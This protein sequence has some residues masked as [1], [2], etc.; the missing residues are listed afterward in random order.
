VRS[1]ECNCRT[2]PRKRPTAEPGL[3]P[4]AGGRV[5]LR[6]VEKGGEKSCSHRLGSYSSPTGINSQ[7]LARAVSACGR[8]RC[9][10]TS[11]RTT[12]VPN[13]LSGRSN[14]QSPGIHSPPGGS[15]LRGLD[16]GAPPGP[17]RPPCYQLYQR[18]TPGRRNSR[19]AEMVLKVL[20]VSCRVMTSWEL[21]PPAD[22]DSLPPQ[23]S[24]SP[25]HAVP[26]LSPTSTALRILVQR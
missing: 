16:W 22:H 12:T 21:R 2:R 13:S 8:S 4:F 17:Y 24:L 25:C 6:P 9:T 26:L 19:P 18:S 20:L 15:I 10:S 23:A 7:G 14:H 3:A 11:K 5:D 1:R